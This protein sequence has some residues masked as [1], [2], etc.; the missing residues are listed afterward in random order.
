MHNAWRAITNT[1]R[2]AVASCSYRRPSRYLHS[3]S[4]R[5]G[6]RRRDWRTAAAYPAPTPLMANNSLDGTPNL[7]EEEDAVQVPRKLQTKLRSADRVFPDEW[8]H[9]RAAIKAAHPEG[10]APPKKLSREAMDGLRFMHSQNPEVFTTPILAE[11]FRISPEAVRRILKSKWE[12][13]RERKQ[14]LAQREKLEAQERYRGERIEETHNI[15][16]TILDKRS[17]DAEETELF[18]SKQDPQKRAEAEKRFRSHR[19]QFDRPRISDNR[20]RRSVK[21]RPPPKEDLFF[22]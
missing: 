17:A 6:L 3:S 19:P 4:A 18:W 1:S 7:S 21:P 22:S 2:N 8:R 9:H 16:Q 15:V 11:K 12:P 5:D 10:W 14:E 20:E 13:S